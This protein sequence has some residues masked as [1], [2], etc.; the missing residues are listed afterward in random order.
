MSEV[1]LTDSDIRHLDAWA[2]TGH[3]YTISGRLYLL[4]C[5]W[6]DY[7]ATAMTRAEAV[8]KYQR[9]HEDVIIKKSDDMHRQ[10]VGPIP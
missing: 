4:K 5:L 2:D 7:Q 10:T 8:N 1:E 6:C 9:E 3:G